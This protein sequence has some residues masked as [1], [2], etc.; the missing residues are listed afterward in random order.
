MT[1]ALRAPCCIHSKLH[2]SQRSIELGVW[3]A[4]SN[5]AP[6]VIGESE[7]ASDDMLEEPL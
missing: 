2:F 7:V 4:G 5:T 1:E 6:R 3:L